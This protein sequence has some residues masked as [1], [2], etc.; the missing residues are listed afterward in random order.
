MVSNFTSL[1]V[2]CFGWIGS[3]LVMPLPVYFGETSLNLL[4]I[5]IGTVALILTWVAIRALLKSGLSLKG[6]SLS[7]KSKD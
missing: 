2:S 7:N 4:D 3:I 6:K 5:V 1:W